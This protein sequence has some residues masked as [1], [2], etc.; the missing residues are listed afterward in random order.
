M[1]RST[2]EKA[3]FPMAAEA[4]ICL[5]LAL[6]L[7]LLVALPLST[8]LQAQGPALTTISDTVY[9]ADGTPAEGIVLISWPSFQSAQGDAVAAGNLTVTIGPQGAF[10]AQLVPNVGASPAGTYY[11][12]VFQ[13]DDGTV[14]TE[15]WAVPAT[16]PTTIAAVLTTPGTGLGNLAATEQYVNA[17][18]AP[19]AID[20]T[21]VHLAGTE[22]IT[23]AKQF[24]V[25]PLLPAPVGATDAANKGY[26]DEAVGNVGGGAYVP[27]AGGT[28]TGPLTLPADPTAPYQAADRNY[29]DNGLLAKADLV[30]GTV[31]T[32]EL[33][34]GVASSATCLTGN[35]TWG[36]CGGGAPA[37]ITYATTA[38]NWAQTISSPL[39]GGSQA[40]ITLTPCPVGVDTTSGAGYQILLSGGGN[41][42]AVSVVTSA[43]GCTSG[44]ASGTIRFTPF[45]SYTAGYT[46]GSASSGIQETLNAGC[47][48]NPTSY[49]NSQCNVTIP[50]N[51]PNSSVNIYNVFGTLYLHSN[52]SVLSGYGTSLNCI[53][54]GACLQIGDLQSSNDFTDNT[55]SGLTF[56]TPLNLAGNPAFAGVA[57]AQ[58][59]RASQIVTI[60]TASA[61]GF[62]VG[63][64]VTILFTD[65][66]SYWGD[67]TVTAVPN[68]TTFQYTHSGPDIAV[69]ASPGVVALAY[70]AVLDNAMDTHLVDISYD[71]VGNN[72]RFN[73]FFD[74]WDDENAT[75]D[76]FNN[77]GASLNDNVNWT[78]SFVFS[79][80]NQ[81]MQVAPVITLR[82]STITANSSN[83]VTDYNSNGL[84]I[85]NTVLQATGPWQ[86][87]SANSTGNYQGAYL[88]N[89][90]SESNNGLNPLSPPRS[91]FPGLGIAGLIA[92]A[93]S[94]ASS[95]QIAGSGGTSGA[96]ASGGTGSAPYS[97]FIVA[98]DTTA[99]TQTSPMQILNWL[100]TGSDSIPVRWPRVAN[101]TDAITYDV[102][103]ITTPTGV[104][105]IFP[106]NGGCPGGS[107][108]TCG[109]VAKGLTQSAAC[110]GSLVCSY[111]DNGSSSTSAYTIKQ[112]NYAGNLDFWPGSI[113]S[114]NKSVLVDTDEYGSVGIGLNGNPL[115]VA[116]LCSNYG[117]ASPGGYT[118]CLASVTSPNNSVPNQTATIM[119]DGAEVGNGM[120]LSKG[121]L[122]FSS[123]PGALISAHHILTLLDSQPALTQATWGSR[124]PA[125]ANDTWIGT[126]VS[127]AVYPASGQLAFG[128][129]VSITNYIAQTG[130][131]IHSNWLERLT[132]SLKE[133]NVPAKFDQSVT[134][135]G[136]SNGCLNVVSGVIG[137]TG[138][139]CGSGGGGGG[140]VSS[141]FGRTGA[142]V[143]TS[144]DYSVAQVTGAAADSAVVHLANSETITGAKTFTNSVAM[145]GNLLLPQGNGY[146]PAV[147]GIGLD[148]AA[149]LPVV[150]IGG[151]TQ[152]VA[153]TSSNISG[154]AG[155]ALALAAAPT[156]C[157]GSF[158][159]GIA[160]NGNANCTTSDV[161]Q[162]A[163]TTQPAGIP[164]W[165]VFWF[166]SATHTPRVIDNNGQVI[167]LGLTNLFNSDPGGD[168]ADN[169]EERNGN[170][171]ESFRVY[172]GYTNGATWQRTSLGFDATDN[173]AVVRSENATSASSPGLG[174][175]IGSGL[176]WVVDATGNLKPWTDNTFN[177]GSDSGNAAKS[178]FAKTS[179][180]SV[181]YGRNDF[182]VPNDGSTGTALDQLAVFNTNSP[183]QAVLASGSSNNTVIGVVQGGAGKSGNAVITW[184]GYAYC[185]FDNATTA[186]DAVIAST[187]TAA[188]CHDTGSGAQPGSQLIGYVD[189]TNTVSGQTNGIRVSLQPPQGGGGNVASVFGRAGAVTAATGDYSVSQV[190]GAAA[191]SAVVHLGGTETITGSKT[192]TSDVTLSGNLI[193]AGN[194]NQAGTGP[195]QWSGQ[196]W[197]GTGVTVPSGMAFSLGV[198]SDNT[199]KCQ[200]SNGASCMAS[201]GGM[202]YPGAGIPNSTGSAWG[203]SYNTSGTGTT[204]ALTASPVFTGSPTVPGYVP[205][206]TAVNG[207]ALSANV[208][209]SASDL[210]T[211]TLPHAQLPALVSGDIPNNA[212]NTTGTAG[213]L[214]ANI[215]ELQVTNLTTDLGNKVSTSTTVNGHAL[216]ANV[217]VSAS[218]LTTGTLPHAQLP[219][220]V[221]GD[222]PN[223]AANT[224][225]TAA[226]LSGTPALP[227]G[228][229]A[230]TPSAGD[231]ST[232]L[233]TTSYVKSETYFS[234]AC[235]VAGSTSVSQNCNWTLPAGMTI[236][237]FDFAANTAPAGCTTYPVM[238]VWDG[239]AAAE[240]GSYSI[241]LSSGTTFYAQV[242]GS[243]NVA[244]GHLL[245][246]KVATAASG[247][248]TNA[249]GMVATVT[250]QMQN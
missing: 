56:R 170:N 103:R 187:S 198:G 206:S 22:T 29:V 219:T 193:V 209:V 190:T 80:G 217:T 215:T 135:A 155:T 7:A 1:L 109:Y 49:K 8:T 132:A 121:R 91:P 98:N 40:A 117:A 141:V 197:T 122:N 129:P 214:S 48:V 194:I 54:R 41:S 164:N 33:G 76:H 75:I 93:S 235:P 61:H 139:A 36:S 221:S 236:T 140:N 199:F 196:E 50:A 227:N 63:D 223:N 248:S 69:Q 138:S 163:E 133:F 13:L 154:Q 145:S 220:L 15:Y 32:G 143:A 116:N 42:E 178:I 71:K 207:H 74:L 204:L 200:L 228:T 58:T 231:N 27:L 222:I 156:Q 11:T 85:E 144:G 123:T 124:P 100:S 211:G 3:R 205:S 179:F 107:G 111:T 60:T 46:I 52:Q 39:T 14:R 216:S 191:D 72:G 157:S 232:K 84:Y 182:E 78:G 173:Y 243:A 234:W 43:G 181:L 162:L 92:G 147:G 106:F 195:T 244:S 120:T 180:N 101:G 174:L 105:A 177:L 226:N 239:T 26:V 64:M 118:S 119:T 237:G 218:D 158:A 88:K 146:V 150:N 192:F 112:A 62:R 89:I 210:T 12:V 95:F 165:G 201:S 77:Q 148:T 137:S 225:G 81:S 149:G 230:S 152:Q 250:Y 229:T 224:T 66:T 24:A 128:T 169:L 233:A 151:T 249:G 19:L 184:H 153:L 30:N 28:M 18:V 47:G 5:V 83:G 97:Y 10:T 188:D 44:A 130:D 45:Y 79:A 183:S 21:V 110:S 240:V 82:D 171:V 245:R 127:G 136:L 134:L 2:T 159:T 57:I 59:Q 99:N 208:T 160:A 126:D 4:V 203:A 87:Y 6:V 25:P 96:F 17:A 67:A 35:S 94:G 51:G 241:A 73:N 166:D 142:V 37:G 34:A 168:P 175:W 9:R 189:V 90:Y 23:G 70:V 186:G 104:G 86:V 213:G 114:V 31:P 113:V 65:S 115:E 247:C 212:A 131:G 20:A 246:I 238:Q 102:I 172:S 242:T 68:S 185:V 53:G 38:L 176:K 16:S 108:G 125:S 55:I 161:I 202:V 167:E